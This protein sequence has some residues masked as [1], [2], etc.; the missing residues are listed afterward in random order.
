MPIVKALRTR[1]TELCTIY[2]RKSVKV[3]IASVLRFVPKRGGRATSATGDENVDVEPISLRIGRLRRRILPRF[4]SERIVIVNML[5]EMLAM[6][7][8]AVVAV[9]F[10]LG[11]CRGRSGDRSELGTLSEHWI[12]KHRMEGR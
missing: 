1:C 8:V 7:C 12:L 5:S 11:R 6:A 3:E 4:R 10:A 2:Y 9:L